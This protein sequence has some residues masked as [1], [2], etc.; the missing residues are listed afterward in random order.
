MVRNSR[1]PINRYGVTNL[2]L[3][4]QV[5]H[6]IG[7]LVNRHRMFYRP[8]PLETAMTRSF[9]PPLYTALAASL[10][11]FLLADVFTPRT[12]HSAMSINLCNHSGPDF[13]KIAARFKEELKPG[14]KIKPAPKRLNLSPGLGDN[15]LFER[16]FL[17]FKGFVKGGNMRIDEDQTY[18]DDGLVKIRAN[19]V[20]CDLGGGR[21]NSWYLFV[22]QDDASRIIEHELSL[23][24]NNKDFAMPRNEA[25]NAHRFI[26]F[27][28]TQMISIKHRAKALGNSASKLFAEMERGGFIR[29]EFMQTAGYKKR[30]R[31]FIDR[32]KT[33]NSVR[34]YAL[35]F[36]FPLKRGDRASLSTRLGLLFTSNTLMLTVIE[37]D[38]A[39]D[40]VI[41]IFANGAI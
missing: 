31:R 29:D 8:L 1:T 21:K 36:G 15:H 22:W 16:Q 38:K 27:R 11:A 9:H 30:L 20:E 7:N 35:P 39:Q 28:G 10:L 6:N 25:L 26:G 5:F 40:R 18:T 32:L 19:M 17:N 24:Y 12:A 33:P 13:E 37:Y 14:E 2:T 3:R 23:F 41:K 4:H 34:I